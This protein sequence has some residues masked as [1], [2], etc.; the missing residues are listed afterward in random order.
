MATTTRPELS[1]RNQYWIERHRFYELK[2]FCL[3]YPLWKKSYH[4][5][6]GF[7]LHP[8]DIPQSPNEQHISDPT[9]RC[10]EAREFYRNRID[11]LERI[12]A[13]TDKSFGRYILKAVTEGLSYE[14]LNARYT[15]PCCKD[16]Y[17]ELYRRFFWLLDKERG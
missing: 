14:H 4:N 5:L 7:N 10:V 3:Q 2:H 1:K 13:L 8:H 16:T 9:E 11:L 12:A 15:V 6:D 17:Y